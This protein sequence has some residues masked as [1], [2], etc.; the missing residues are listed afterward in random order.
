MMTMKEAKD[1]IKFGDVMRCAGSFV[2]SQYSGE[3][4]TEPIAARNV[5]PVYEIRTMRD[6]IQED[7]GEWEW[8]S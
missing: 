5:E 1:Q 2:C 3:Y 4:E 8:P 6:L 7:R